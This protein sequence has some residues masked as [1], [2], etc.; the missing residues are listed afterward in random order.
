MK[1]EPDIF[2]QV[3]SYSLGVKR[4][5]LELSPQ[6]RV[7]WAKSDRGKES[8][9]WL[10]VWCHLLD[11][12][13]A[14]YEVLQL[15]PVTTLEMFRRD[16]E[17][18]SAEQALAL[19]SALVA[20]HDLGKASPAFQQKN[21]DCKQRVF[22][23]GLDW[24]LRF[25][26]P[27][28]DDVPHSVISYTALRQLLMGELR[29]SRS[30][31]RNIA[32]A[33]AMHHGWPITQE[34]AAAVGSVD[35]GDAVWSGLRRELFLAVSQTVGVEPP[36]PALQ[37]EGAC[38][39]R[40]AGLTSF[41]DWIGS[42]LDFGDASL[43]LFEYWASARQ[44]AAQRLSQLGWRPRRPFVSVQRTLAQ[45]F[46]Y[47]AEG[48]FVPRPLQLVVEQL[49]QDVQ[50]PVLLILEAPMGEGKTE[51]GFF[52]AVELQRQLQ[53]RGLYVGLPTKATGNAMFG[54]TLEFLRSLQRSTPI[55]LQLLHGATLLNRDYCELRYRTNGDDESA[56]DGVTAE[57]YFS[58]RKRG[59]LSEAGV[60]T[61]D[62]ALLGILPVK[63]QFVRLWGLGNRVVLV[64]EV[65]AYDTYT[66]NLIEQLLEWLHA[67]GSSVILMSATLP[68]SKK[69]RLLRAWM[70]NQV[71][72][73]AVDYPRVTRV[74]GG[75][76]RQAAFG[77]RP[78]PRVFLHH[79][80][81][82]NQFV[83][84]SLLQQVENGGCFACIVNTVDRAQQIFQL[85]RSEAV[86][87]DLELFHARFPLAQRQEIEDR[88]LRKF[89]KDRASR[90]RRAVLVATQVVE[91]S[92]DLD[93]D[94]MFT[95]LAP[96]DLML[97]RAGRLHRHPAGRGARF[98]HEVPRLWLMGMQA[99]N[100]PPDFGCYSWDRV[101]ALYV[102]LRTW[103]FL[104][105]QV[106]VDLQHDIDHWVQTVYD[107]EFEVEPELVELFERARSNLEQKVVG[108][109]DQAHYATI[110]RPRDGSWAEVRAAVSD[111]EEGLDTGSRAVSTRLGDE[112]LNLVP[113]YRLEEQC[114]LDIH[115]RIEVPLSVRRL[116]TGMARLLYLR[117]VRTSRRDLVLQLRKT[118]PW[119][120]TPLLKGMVPL[121]LNSAG[122][123][124]F[125]GLRVRLDE[126]LGL[127]YE[128]GG[129]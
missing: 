64:D 46:Q 8:G 2:C 51:A 12:G 127:L 101:Y 83:A 10:P 111:P 124:D 36:V 53:A 77:C 74:C 26:K 90:P 91:Q 78:Q 71:D 72:E 110:G 93:F 114:F 92:L 84:H 126:S 82:E 94:G 20:L 48:A 40:L 106:L 18:P 49:V 60:G 17:A 27:P 47:L 24:G 4:F 112:S 75:E 120:R 89:G 54:R 117:S 59:L 70:A 66:G 69:S 115:R 128:K 109:G 122:E 79:H 25:P 21:E 129:A 43:P 98:G 58:D 96:I 102:L 85:L 34:E 13:A 9:Q 88:V 23:A 15:E 107:T 73:S 29:W 50:H 22:A 63:H 32:Q 99:G 1:S 119:D 35:E 125:R 33:V 68:A 116:D 52:A 113:L 45:T 11:V 42:S 44:R 55:D 38:F 56:A 123:S 14:A 86:D 103:H 37:V 95:D 5:V 67:L 62:Q 30:S 19:V 65:H 87:V 80:A 105:E 108:Q 118:S 81:A 7:L 16:F 97:Q 3:Q 76:V 6:A 121:F 57:S 61:I 31:A 41:A 39:Q 104:R 100:Q 28:P